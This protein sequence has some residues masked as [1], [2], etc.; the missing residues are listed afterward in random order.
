MT[1]RYPRAPIEMAIS[2]TSL[3][4]TVVVSIEPSNPYPIAEIGIQQRSGLD[5]H[6]FR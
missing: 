1:R 4:S 3:F 6:L 2:M 5:T